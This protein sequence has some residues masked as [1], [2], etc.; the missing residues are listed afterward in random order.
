MQLMKCW[1]RLVPTY[2]TR[3]INSIA[4]LADDGVEEDYEEPG[5]GNG[6]VGF[7][8]GNVDGFGDLYA[9]YFDEV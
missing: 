1:L 4:V 7:M 3:L 5:G 9:D 8:F 2:H 6:F